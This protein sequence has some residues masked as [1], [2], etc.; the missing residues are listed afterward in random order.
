M[1]NHQV[2][3]RP[4]PRTET[5]PLFTSS[6]YEPTLPAVTSL[7]QID[8]T[9][10]ELYLHGDPHAA[11]RLLR[12]QAPVFWNEGGASGF[13]GQPF[14]AVTNYAGCV[15]IFGDPVTFTGAE[16]QVLDIDGHAFRD[17]ITSQVG[18]V[19]RKWRKAVSGFTGPASIAHHAE[20]VHDVIRATLPKYIS[21]TTLDVVG[22]SDALPP[23]MVSALLELTPEETEKVQRMYQVADVA[24]GGDG[25]EVAFLGET[26]D[27][28]ISARM[29]DPGND[30]ISGMIGKATKGDLTASQLT[31]Y[32]F[33]VIM[34]AFVGTR[35][36][37][38]NPIITLAHHPAQFARLRSEPELIEDGR[39]VEELLRWAAH[40]VHSAR[41]VTRD[42]EVLGQPVR[43]GDLVAAFPASANRDEKAFEDPYVFDVGRRGG[44]R[45]MSFS[46][47]V[48]QCLG[49]YY[50]RSV[51]NGLIRELVDNV[52]AI[53][54]V[55]PTERVL[56]SNSVVATHFREFAVE[57][58]Y[59][60][61]LVA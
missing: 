4:G 18:E 8:L 55:V 59:R 26:V 7:D 20:S 6:P 34:G 47:G 17:F 25:V 2:E 1:N 45:I 42:G 13:G 53:E 49:Q 61:A 54:E 46:T 21:G 16:G 57:V 27:A 60:P 37:I 44:S 9:D 10:P 50:I 52:T 43:A 24:E 36:A 11:F 51:T 41:R 15:E 39:A 12:Q 56:M 3:A 48:H 33:N 32:V 28:L 22:L 5:S 58:D 14:W 29:S 38:H 31:L 30:I 40:A 35:S 23:L 19:H